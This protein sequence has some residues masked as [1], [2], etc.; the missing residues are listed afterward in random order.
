MAQI[1]ETQEISNAVLDG[2]DGFILSHETSV[3]KKPH[4][5]TVLQ[6]VPL[7]HAREVPKVAELQIAQFPEHSRAAP[8]V[9]EM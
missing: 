5:S 3:G 8:K 9:V 7:V 6:G 4:E 1:Q 2:A